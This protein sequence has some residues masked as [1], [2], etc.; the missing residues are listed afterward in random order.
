M[1]VIAEA[2]TPEGFAPFGGVIAA[3]RMA[4]ERHYFDAPLANLRPA[5]GP[6][7]SIALPVVTVLPL[8]VTMMER[9][10]FSSQSFVPMAPGSWLVIVAPDTGDAPDMAGLRAFLPAEGEGLTLAPGTWHY[11]LTSLTAGVPFALYMWRDGG[12]YD[13][14]LRDVQP[15]TV[16]L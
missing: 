4:G 10:A 5:A 15:R 11:P 12:P 2:L 1:S 3:P 14:E 8:K 13:E 16:M 6:S 9:H 7:L